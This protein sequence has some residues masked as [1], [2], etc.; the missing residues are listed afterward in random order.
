MDNLKSIWNQLSCDSK[1]LEL[2]GNGDKESIF[3]KLENEEL[4][5][6]KFNP[7]LIVF[8]I[9]F[10][11]FLGLLILN[12][13]SVVSYSKLLGIVFVTLASISIA[14]LSQ[15]VKM[16]LK[17]FEHDKSSMIF[18]QK[19]REKL[20][21]SKNMLVLGLILQ[22][23]FLTTGLYLIIFYNTEAVNPGY[24]YPFLGFMFGLGGAVIGGSL[25]FYH[26]HY[27]STYQLIDH[28]LSE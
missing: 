14:I 13:D 26:R 2:K 24:L 21:Q 5:R 11:L 18:L 28:F 9:S 19:V 20:N 7:L 22:N 25:A 17:Q 6:K 8:I 23:I 4:L 12:N 27:K 1:Q 16:P 3:A 10:T 15:G